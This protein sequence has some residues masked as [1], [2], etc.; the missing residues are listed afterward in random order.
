MLASPFT[1]VLVALLIR[2]MA[3]PMVVVIRLL[4]TLTLLGLMV[5]GPTATSSILRPLPTPIAITLLDVSLA[6]LVV[7]SLVR[8]VPTLLRTPRVRC[9]REPTLGWL[10]FVGTSVPTAG[11]FP[12]HCP[13]CLSLLTDILSFSRL[14]PWRDL[15]VP[16][17]V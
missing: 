17:E 11:L 12:T 7:L 10:K 13:P 16:V 3:V 2:P 8:P 15:L 6:H 1:L 9:T 14:S 5:L 4:S